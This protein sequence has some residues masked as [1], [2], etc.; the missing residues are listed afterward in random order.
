M[1]LFQLNFG[2]YGNPLT[3]LKSLI[4]MILLLKLIV[5]SHKAYKFVGFKKSLIRVSVRI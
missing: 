2:M 1:N 4:Y 5:C 3:D